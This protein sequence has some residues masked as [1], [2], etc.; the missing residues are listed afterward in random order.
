MTQPSAARP[1]PADPA[2]VARARGEEA[3]EDAG[4]SPSRSAATCSCTSRCST[5]RSPTAAATSYDFAPFFEAIKPYVRG[6]DLGLCH[7]E[8]PIGPGPADHL[9]DLQHADRPCRVGRAQRLGRLLDGLQPLARQGTRGST[10][11]S[12]RSTGRGSS[13]PARS[14][15]QG[16]SERPT[17][18]R[19][20]GVKVGYRRLHR[21]HQRLHRTAAPGRSTSTRPPTRRRARRRSS[22]SAR[23]PASGRRGGDRQHPLGRRVLGRA[24]RVAARGR[25]EADDSKL[26]T[27]V[28]GQ[29]PHVVQPIERINGKFVVFSEGN[30]VSNQGAASRPAGRD[31]GRARSPCSHFQG[32]RAS[33]SRCEGSPT[34]RPGS[35]SAT[36]RCCRRGRRRPR[37][38]RR[39]ARVAVSH[40][41]HRRRGQRHRGGLGPVDMLAARRGDGDRDDRARERAVRRP[42][43]S[44]GR[45][46]RRP[47]RARRRRARGDGADGRRSSRASPPP[48]SPPTGSR[49]GSGRSPRPRIP[50]E[51]RTELQRAL[52]RSHAAGMG[53]PVEREVVRAMLFLRARSLAIGRSGAR[54]LL[55]ETMLAMLDAGLD[56]VVPEHGSLGASGDL[57]PLA[58]CA[59]AL[60]GEGE[61]HGRG[62]RRRSP[63]ARGAREAPGSSRRC[64]ARRRGWR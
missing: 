28:V 14:R 10:A 61:V 5:V 21:R 17:I 33:G 30:L 40:R 60:I 62:R 1:A 7:L 31:P 49:P 58:H 47:R 27:V 56:P 15:R 32:A 43:W 2:R 44:S 36:T 38:R 3:A 8:T 12:E 18:L 42:R 45:P 23:G 54:P 11:R 29:R 63:A 25:E 57:A 24:E 16:P 19:V 55:A 48:T 46:P 9:S 37:P 35:A 41:D 4:A 6:V 64:S 20:D 39:A 50:A 34:C 52:M 59:L 22:R 51:R 53:P 26:I 13:T